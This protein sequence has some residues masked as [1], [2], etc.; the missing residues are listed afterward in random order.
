MK[1]I[2]LTWLIKKEKYPSLFYSTL[3]ICLQEESDLNNAWSIVLNIEPKADQSQKFEALA[4]FLFTEGA[5]TTWFNA[6][7]TI[8]LY[9][10][11][12]C[13]AKVDVV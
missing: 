13:V 9:E 6:G 3:G 4:D 7:N 12:Q 11:Y 5:P 8:L 10:G 1:K 2:H